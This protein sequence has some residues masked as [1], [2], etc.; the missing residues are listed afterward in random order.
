MSLK[1]TFQILTLLSLCITH[2]EA[3]SDPHAD[4]EQM[5]SERRQANPAWVRAQS[6]PAFSKDDPADFF[7]NSTVLAQQR[8]AGV[9]LKAAVAAQ[10]QA[11]ALLYT[12]PPGEYRMADNSGW[13]FNNV[14][15]FTLN[16]SG[17][18]IWFERD[19]P[20]DIPK[21]LYVLN[22]KNVA[23]KN[24]QLDFDP[25]ATIQGTIES[26]SPDHKTIE[27]KIDPAW[28]KV[29]VP[30]G[31]FEIYMPD[32]EYVH[33]IRRGMHHT[34]STLHDG[35]ML[36][37]DVW[38][39]RDLT[40]NFD[41]D[42]LAF[43]G[44]D[45]VVEPGYL[46]ALNYRRSHAVTIKRSEKITFEDVDVWQAPGGAFNEHYGIGGNVYRRCR[47]IRKPGTR[48]IHMGTADTF[49]SAGHRDGPQLIECEFGYASDDIINIFGSWRWLLK[50]EDPNTVLVGSPVPL[51]DTLTFYNRVE[52]GYLDEA[53]VD[54]IEEVT[55]P[56]TLA[57]VQAIE[58][59]ADAVHIIHRNAGEVFRVTLKT[60]VSIDT[61]A[62]PEVL[63]DAHSYNAE[64]LLVKDCYFHDSFSRAQLF[65]GTVGAVIENNIWDRMNSGIEIFEESW[66]YE[67][68]PAPQNVTYSNNTVMNMGAGSDAVTV[69]LAPKIVGAYDLMNTQPSKN[70]VITDNLFINSSGIT[71]LYVDGG[72]IQNNTLV[73][74]R[75]FERFS[76]RL[77]TSSRMLFGHKNFFPTGRNS[78]MSVWSS[79]NVEVSG[80][81]LYCSGPLGEFEVLDIGKWAR[82][83][84]ES[85]NRI[86][87]LG[88]EIQQFET[89]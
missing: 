8:Q 1:Q 15:N 73:E 21:R 87:P 84:T 71:M 86:V 12:V 40:P 29:A 11:G 61:N 18:R 36:T 77:D 52:I 24:L 85:R 33:Q 63:I 22:S 50:Q 39:G 60:P 76:G 19:D 32:G 89:E 9:D 7:T 74:P 62:T 43:F 54:T 88:K 17:A 55:D 6:T 68:G 28:P 58:F 45:Y 16:G 79:H 38:D 75:G 5:L 3:A 37:I 80:N 46:I 10:I 56:A 49:F 57:E 42:R 64:N 69:G 30:E 70:I 31:A 51:G 26:I 83:V 72:T 14:E 27:M 53:E 48:R 23:I 20:T 67:M 2:A 35:D 66:A 44:D 47:A 82:N 13:V 81:T 4:I 65:G 34:N 78:A 25:P 41:A 59:P